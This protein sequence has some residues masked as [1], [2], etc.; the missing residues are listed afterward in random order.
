MIV[1]YRGGEA[2]EYFRHSWR[3]VYPSLKKAAL[4][5]V[6]SGYLQAV[7]ADYGQQTRVIPNIVD[8]SVFSLS[9][10]PPPVLPD[11]PW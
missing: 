2:S 3:R 4:V 7:F 8:Q 6:P 1:N 10:G 5:V 11:S 9:P